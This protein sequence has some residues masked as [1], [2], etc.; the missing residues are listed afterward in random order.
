MECEGHRRDS[1]KNTIQDY[2][3]EK[4]YLVPRDSSKEVSK[5]LE[6]HYLIRKW[7]AYLILLL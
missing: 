1:E 4:D 2:I 6:R 5:K 3:D 7:F